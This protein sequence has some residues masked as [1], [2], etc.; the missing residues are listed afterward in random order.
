MKK[1]LKHFSGFH[2][3]VAGARYQLERHTKIIAKRKPSIYRLQDQNKQPI[4]K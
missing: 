4:K 2:K 1:P 3:L